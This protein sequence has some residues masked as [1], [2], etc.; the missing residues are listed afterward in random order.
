[1]SS[2]PAV[3]RKE[4]REITRL[5]LPVIGAMVAQIMLSTTD[6]IMSG[7]LSED[8]LAA[9]GIGNSLVNPVQ[10]FLLGILMAVNPVVSHLY[11]G[12]RF[13]EIGSRFRQGL[14]LAAFLSVPGVLLL[15]YAEPALHWMQIPADLHPEIIGYMHAWAWGLPACLLFLALRF[16][17]EGVGITRP[18]LF[19][20]IAAVPL[21]I[22]A[23]YVFMYGKLGL[24]AMGPVGV[25]Y[26]T[27]TVWVFAFV[28][29][30]AWT[31]SNK[32]FHKYHL[33]GHT[34]PRW[35]HL[36]ELIVI[37]VPNGISIGMEI[38]MFALVTLFL[39]R[40][41][42]Q[43]VASHQIALNVASFLFMIPMGLSSA[44]SI[45][46]GQ[47]AGAGSLAGVKRTAGAGLGLAAAGNSCLTIF[48][49][50]FAHALAGLYT[51][52]S[53]VR[54]LAASLL[55]LAAVFQ[56][57]DGIQVA[58]LG[59]LRG[60]KDTRVP[61]LSNAMAYWLAGIPAG[62]YLGLERGMGAAG[63][64][65]GLIIG[66]TAAAFLHGARVYYLLNRKPDFLLSLSEKHG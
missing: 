14:W 43:V 48:T 45:R 62:Y 56:L 57:S 36:K 20:M 49:L 41:G 51:T 28:C 30:A 61:M 18:P 35:N 2:T 7:R 11:G 1:M 34:R 4:V 47:A 5:A 40:L 31:F 39:G 64:W 22:A 32:G 13:S 66:L 46:I 21:N 19:I 65:W 3:F 23:N 59:I 27:S 37:G 58:A 63:F 53:G 6:T 17:N 52:E 54:E 9:V 15:V 38:M 25:G 50:T 8:T 24:P 33:L 16:F 12:K 10:L 42:S 55:L 60:L 29:L 26:A 44:I